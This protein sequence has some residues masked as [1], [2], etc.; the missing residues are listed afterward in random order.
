[1]KD[2]FPVSDSTRQ[3]RSLSFWSGPIRGRSTESTVSPFSYQLATRQVG[4]P[5]YSS[6]GPWSSRWIAFASL[7]LPR[8]PA[9]LSLLRFVRSPVAYRVPHSG[10]SGSTRTP[11]LR[12]LHGKLPM[13]AAGGSLSAPSRGLQERESRRARLFPP[14]RIL[15]AWADAA[16]AGGTHRVPAGFCR[17]LDWTPGASHHHPLRINAATSQLGFPLLLRWAG[18]PSRPAVKGREVAGQ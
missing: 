18:G 16:P 1:M 17:P 6:T 7:P 3:T 15:H 12:S 8:E 9:L 10:C 11:A 14:V 13:A 5:R 4:R 2:C